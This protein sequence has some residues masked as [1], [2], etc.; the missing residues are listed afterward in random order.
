MAFVNKQ[1]VPISFTGGLSAKSDA[2]QVQAPALLELENALFDKVGAL[3]KRPGYNI[4]STSTL[5]GGTITSAAAID[6]F[7]G[8]LV[9]F[10]NQD[11]F[12]FMESNGSWAN[13][14]PAISLI[15]SSQQI[16]RR[17]ADQQI[18]PDCANLGGVN[19]FVW[20]DSRGT[21][22]YSVLDAVTGAYAVSD[23]PLVG[24]LSGPKVLAF[25]G[26]FYVF[27]ASNNNLAYYTINPA[28]PGVIS[29]GTTILSDGAPGLPYDVTVSNGRLY[30]V[31]FSAVNLQFLYILPGGALSAIVVVGAGSTGLACG[32]VGD[33]AGHI[34]ISFSSGL[35]AV[36]VA[37]YDGAPSTPTLILA[38]TLLEAVAA[39]TLA[40]IESLTPGSLHLAWEIPGAI[41]SQQGV[42][43]AVIDPTGVIIREGTIRSVGIA[44]KPFSYGGN[45]FVNLAYQSTL[46]STYFTVLL[47]GT[48]FVIVAKSEPQVGGGLRTN[49]LM[50]EANQTS[51]GVILW[52]NLT[53]GAFLSEDNTSFSLLGAS[54]TVLD[55]TDVNKFNAVTF[56]NNLLFVGGILQSY[57]GVSVV[58]QNFH[59]FPEDATL[60]PAAGGGALSAG[61]YQ[62]QLVYAWMD[63][64]GQVQLSTPSPAFTVTATLDGRVA[65]VAPTLRLSAKT[66]V[67]IRIYRTQVNGV[68][69]QEVTSELAPLLNDPTVDTVTF[70]DVAADVSI[71]ANQVI[72]TTG[73]ILANAA[74]PSCS[75]V[76]LYQ[77]RVILG[78]LEDPNLLWVS[79][80]R[81]NNSN[82]NV[83]PAEFSA[84]LTVGVSQVGGPIAALGLMDANLII[85]KRGSIFVLNGDGPNDAGGGSSFSDPQIISST[86]GCENPNSIVLTGAGLMFQSPTKGIWMIGR[87][88]GEPQYIGAGVD[89]EAREFLV[90]SATLD[91]G[92][93]SVIFTTT[94]GP[95]LVYDYLIGQWGT[96]TNHPAVDAVPFGGFF[97][98]ARATGEIY[99]QAPGTFSDG[100][101]AGAQVPYSMS[102]TTP[103]L[104]YASTLGYQSIFRVF[105]L[106]RYRGAHSLTVDVGYDFAPDFAASALIPASTLPVAIAWGTDPLWGSSTPWG[107]PW[108]PYV[109]QVNM[110]RQKCTSFRLRIGDVAVGGAATEGYTIS[111][112]LLELGQLPA[113]VRIPVTRKFAAQ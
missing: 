13:R 74:P 36:G 99:Q 113:G 101:P 67:T 15:N 69:F 52:A 45:L 27:A 10:N 79:K 108:D 88:L 62:Y 97:S 87:G 95:A 98:Y 103:W 29:L 42:H 22:R 81:T 107:G 109:W 31:Y 32:V 94:N 68:V 16:I 111:A 30:V 86:V 1:T 6:A 39:P 90:S 70:T 91:P 85:F 89:D 43:A 105:L 4:L 100:L 17:G 92:S 50:G 110:S 55:F 47:T 48:P 11:V 54:A 57:D 14:G 21:C 104:S 72:Y 25:A 59:V 40:G 73:G 53:K 37:C 84:S 75:M 56:S 26:L 83:I 3:N 63:R 102:L 71:A 106:G 64:F 112:L 33:S 58:E 60:T 76:S 20:E 28:N 2:L 93:N 35:P 66:G 19:V 77:D 65:I 78:G 18:N 12:S 34:W 24:S 61:Q 51:P 41:P 44:S 7:N 8:E 49:G 23:Q 5:D 46:Q 96:W 80:N 9:L 82:F 38:P